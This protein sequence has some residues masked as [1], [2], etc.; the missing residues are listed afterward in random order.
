MRSR[1]PQ[2]EETGETFRF[3][4]PSAYSR[5]VRSLENFPELATL[6]MALE[7]HAARSA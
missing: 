4:I 5:M 1:P 6:R 7:S 2:A 3:Q